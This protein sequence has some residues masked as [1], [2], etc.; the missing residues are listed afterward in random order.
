MFRFAPHC[1]A[2]S[3]IVAASPSNPDPLWCILLLPSAFEVITARVMPNRWISFRLKN[4]SQYALCYQLN[5]RTRRGN[6]QSEEKR[7][8]QSPTLLPTSKLPSQHSKTTTQCRNF[9]SC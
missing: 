5:S 2:V 7:L 4:G 8:T 9:R 1:V 6:G 3:Q